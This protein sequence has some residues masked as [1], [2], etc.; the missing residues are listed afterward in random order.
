MRLC[1]ADHSTVCAKAYPG[2]RLKPSLAV[3]YLFILLFIHIY[4]L[5]V[6]SCNAT[7]I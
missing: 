4:S 1:V 7:V 6:Y 2:Y 3:Y 5:A